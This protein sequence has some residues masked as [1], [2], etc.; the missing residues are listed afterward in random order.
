[1]L[2]GVVTFVTY[3]SVSRKLPSVFL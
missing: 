2:H 3:Q 1:M